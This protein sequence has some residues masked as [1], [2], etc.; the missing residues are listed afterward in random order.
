MK[1]GDFVNIEFT[2]RIKGSQD[3]FD[4]TDGEKAKTAGIYNEKTN[5]GP[6]PIV[7][8]A[9]QLIPGLEDAVKEMNVGEKKTVEIPPEK[10]FGSKNPDMVKLVPMSVFKDNKTDPS[11]GKIVDFNGL[12]GMV[13]NVDGGRVK[14]DF[15]HPLADKVIEYD[16]EIKDEITGNVER[17]SA[18]VR[19]TTGIKSDDVSAN[20][21]DNTASIEIKNYDFPKRAKKDMADMIM[22]WI[23]GISK[24]NFVDVFEKI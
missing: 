19:Y 18:V 13:M 24:V 9:R 23:S 16:I 6:I 3:I 20:I 10:A 5:Y 12:R 21:T 22:K 1:D 17:V 14:I 2:G 7:V 4:T 8:G 11:P 15:N